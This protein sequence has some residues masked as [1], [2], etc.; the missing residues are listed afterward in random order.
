MIEMFSWKL[1]LYHFLSVYR[2]NTLYFPVLFLFKTAIFVMTTVMT[3]VTN[4]ALRDESDESDVTHGPDL[5]TPL[6]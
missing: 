6:Y 2:Y 3:K 1:E 4:V 5:H